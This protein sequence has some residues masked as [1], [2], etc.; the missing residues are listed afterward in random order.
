MTCFGV[1]S[2]ATLELAERPFLLRRQGP[3]YTEVSTY[4]H[5]TFEFHRHVADDVKF[6]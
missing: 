2:L 4:F 3:L 5:E 6:A 1:L